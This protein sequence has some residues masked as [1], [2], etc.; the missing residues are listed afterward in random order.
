VGDPVQYRSMYHIE[1]AIRDLKPMVDNRA[2][3]EGCITEAYFSSVYFVKE[4]N[5]NAPMM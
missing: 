3:V 4:H 2:G 1:R 5:D